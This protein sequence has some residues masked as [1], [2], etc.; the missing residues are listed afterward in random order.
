MAYLKLHFHK[1]DWKNYTL[2]ILMAVF[3]L[4][5]LIYCDYTVYKEDIFHIVI[6][7]V[8]VDII[9]NSLILRFFFCWKDSATL[10]THF[11]SVIL[12]EILRISPQSPIPNFLMQGLF[13]NNKV[14]GKQTVHTEA[15]LPNIGGSTF[16]LID[17]IGTVPSSRRNFIYERLFAL[18]VS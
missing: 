12:M 17:L 6:I 18:Q 5:I 2:R 13:S 7:N 3:L 14:L 11:F 8:S 1:L 9:T 15:V 10:S 16:H 4:Y